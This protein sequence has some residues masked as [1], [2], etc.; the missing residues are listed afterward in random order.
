MTSTPMIKSTAEITGNYRLPR[1]STAAAYEVSQGDLAI[2]SCEE[3]LHASQDATTTDFTEPVSG[4]NCTWDPAS[5]G[6]APSFSGGMMRLASDISGATGWKLGAYTDD[7]IDLSTRSGTEYLFSLWFYNGS[8]GGSY[9]K[10]IAALSNTGTPGTGQKQFLLTTNSATGVLTLW[11]MSS[12]YASIGGFDLDTAYYIGIVAK[13]DTENNLVGIEV[14][15][16]TTTISPAKV[17][18]TY[19]TYEAPAT[20]TS[21]GL[22]LG[23]YVSTIT[24]T[25]QPVNIGF[26][27]FRAS[28]PS[29]SGLNSTREVFRDWTRTKDNFS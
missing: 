13:V 24:G 21:G 25:I 28:D 9:T 23:S 12:D 5:S 16:A 10:Q 19:L 18:S 4:R 27:F 22:M 15:K 6:T 1:I 26:G 29:Y 11:C 17:M 2:W 14:Y 8:S 3:A 20:L 7:G